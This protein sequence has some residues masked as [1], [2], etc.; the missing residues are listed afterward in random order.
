MVLYCGI[1]PG[2]FPIE[3]IAIFVR[4]NDVEDDTQATFHTLEEIT[5][6]T[7]SDLEKD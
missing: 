2:E 5:S 7:Q 3:S 4:M 1:L 6:I